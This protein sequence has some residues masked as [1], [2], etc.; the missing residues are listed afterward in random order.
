ML[1]KYCSFMTQTNVSL[2]GDLELVQLTLQ[3]HIAL[4]SMEAV[5][6]LR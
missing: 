3:F 1:E 4:T 2:P 5:H 6:T